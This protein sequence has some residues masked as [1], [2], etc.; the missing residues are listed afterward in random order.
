MYFSATKFISPAPVSYCKHDSLGNLKSENGQAIPSLVGSS[1]NSDS[2]S[3]S[4]FFAYRGGIKFLINTGP[5][6]IPW[7]IAVPSNSPLLRTDTASAG[8]RG[9]SALYITN[10]VSPSLVSSR[11]LYSESQLPTNKWNR[12]VGHHPPFWSWWA[13][14]IL[15]KLK[16]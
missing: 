7:R 9:I 16:F 5:G 6:K 15:L 3:W 12:D 14:R 8:Q 13:S 1:P 11:E 10:S 2:Q 4:A